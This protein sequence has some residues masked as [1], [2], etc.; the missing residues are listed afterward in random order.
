M[1]GKMTDRTTS[2]MAGKATGEMGGS[3]IIFKP[4]NLLHFRVLLE[5]FYLPLKIPQ[6]SLAEIGEHI[7]P[8]FESL[9]SSTFYLHI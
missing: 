6:R 1:Q 8:L 3:G 2:K 5:T 7:K 9:R 4:Q